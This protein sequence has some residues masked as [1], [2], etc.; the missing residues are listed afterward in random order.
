MELVATIVVAGLAI[1]ALLSMWSA[2]SFQVVRNEGTAD[3]V[4]YSQALMEE[5]AS[6]DFDEHSES[7][8][9]SALGRDG[10]NIANASTYNDVDDFIGTTDSRITTPAPGY[11]RWASVE[12]VTLNAT[13][14]WTACP[15]P[16]VCADVNN[17]TTCNECCY[18]RITVNVKRN[19]FPLNISVAEVVAGY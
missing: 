9:S 8:W 16:Y 17:C 5:I 19:N 1:P 18:K 3:A 13:N 14:T 2:I 12:Y 15:T 10:E 4:I 11:S 7:P 6:K